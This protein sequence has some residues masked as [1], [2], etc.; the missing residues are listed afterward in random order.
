MVY[1]NCHFRITQK[2][3]IRLNVDG[4][5]DNSFNT[6]LGFYT[7]FGAYGGIE[8]VGV[9]PDGKI[10][11]GGRFDFYNGTQE[12]A[13]IRL[14]TDGTKDTSFNQITSFDGVVMSFSQLSD[15]KT[16]VGGGFVS[17]KGKVMNN[18]AR[19]NSDASE[20]ITFDLGTG[21][22]SV[23]N[24]VVTQSD[25]KILVG[26]DFSRFNGQIEKKF[27]RLNADGTKD[28]SFLTGTGFDNIVNTIVVQPDGKILVGGS[29]NQYNNVSVGKIIRLNSDGT[30][31]TT[32]SAGA[33]VDSSVFSIVV[34]PDG[35]ILVGGNF[36]YYNLTTTYAMIR[37]NADGSRDMTFDTQSLFAFLDSVHTIVLQNDGKI[38]VGGDFTNNIVRL[39]PDGSKDLTFNIGTGFDSYVLAIALQY[40]G[41]I[42][43]GGYFKIFNNDAYHNVR[44]IRLNSDGTKDMTFDSESGFNP[45][46]GFGP[47]VRTIALQPDNKILIG[48]YFSIFNGN[49]ANNFTRLNPDGTQDTTF[50]IGQGFK[51]VLSNKSIINS[52][53]LQVDGKILLGGFFAN[54][55]GSNESA[56]LIGL[57][58]GLNLRTENFHNSNSFTISPN[59]VK[60]FLHIQS[61]DFTAIT[62]V[63]IYDLQ[64]KL[65]QETSTTT[66]P[67]SSFAKGLYIVK[68]TTEN[69]ELNKKF[70]KE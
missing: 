68:V 9:Q 19:L 41:K 69:G 63:K 27:I 16:I 43:I 33:G 30:I 51:G 62:T 12:K 8:K 17:Y 40:D 49:E 37:L 3:L 66:I 5:K 57:H 29:F 44:I 46:S 64:G 18:I 56:M 26:G 67:V 53:S 39:N 20:D 13:I 45:G 48:G 14:N 54:Y 50:N 36:S 60:D 7:S 55:K 2:K 11:A 34:Q 65:I 70:V 28:T 61:N 42:I 31:D 10:L 24:S 38:I 22:S 59:P 1:L 52:I 4:S 15:G 6:G 25:G 47:F 58:S 21:F 32:F 23:V 35:K